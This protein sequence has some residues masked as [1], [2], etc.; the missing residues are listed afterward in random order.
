MEHP[1]TPSTITPD[2]PFRIHPAVWLIA[3]GIIA[4]L[5]AIFVF[6]V[7]VGTVITYGFIGLMLISHLFMH[8][9]HGSH[10]GHGQHGGAEAKKDGPAGDNQS[11]NKQAGQSGG[12]H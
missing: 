8:G 12:C 3:A 2:R 4:A 11:D 7:A 9:G 5:A 1:H 6:K 10:G